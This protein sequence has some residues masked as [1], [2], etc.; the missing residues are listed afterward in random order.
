MISEVVPG[1]PSLCSFL[2]RD[3]YP[4][5]L[6]EV[7]VVIMTFHRHRGSLQARSPARGGAL[8]Y[9]LCFGLALIILVSALLY[10]LNMTL[11]C[12]THDQSYIRARFL[13]DSGVYLAMALMKGDY[14]DWVAHV[15]PRLPLR[16]DRFS[17]PNYSLE[18]L[19]GRFEI[20]EAS[21]PQAYP[22][23]ASECY[24]TL[25]S[26]GYSG[27]RTARSFVTIKI[28]SPLVNNVIFSNG[29]FDFGCWGDPILTGPVLVNANGDEGRFQAGHDVKYFSV[30]SGRWEHESF[31]ISL[32]S[33]IKA[34]GKIFL[35]SWNDQGTWSR[36]PIYFSGKTAAGDYTIQDIPG[37]VNHGRLTILT[38]LNAQPDMETKVKI[39]S[40][41]ELLSSYKTK[42][43]TTI[44]DVGSC[45]DG[46]LAEFVEG[47]NT[48][49]ISS[50]KMKTVGKVFDK[51]IYLAYRDELLEGMRDMCHISNPAIADQILKNSVTWDD[52]DYL[53]FAYPP[54]LCGDLDGDGT[55]ETQGDYFEVK[56]PVRDS[57]I[58]SITLSRDTPKVVY[59]RTNKTDYAGE[60]GPQAP[61]LYV[62][63]NV[64]GKVALVYDVADDS[65]DPDFDRLHTCILAQDEASDDGG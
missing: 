42:P 41:K 62:R 29:N 2:I 59:L 35:K 6:H 33:E 9:V 27:L 4:S 58:A 48:L 13:A 7:W 55:S 12:V 45:A 50:A 36:E 52:P 60:R 34:Q 32:S 1:G 56:R 20:S 63:G 22:P 14:D 38:E 18:A 25:V 15:R 53:P 54:D 21:I 44:V 10:R 65:L 24:M 30:Y 51:D 43:G 11:R 28:T 49:H 31:H 5:V 37:E 47:T 39:P 23:G 46:V 64:K 3:S 61:I 17:D 57:V 26:T 40:M 8:V 19:G 16:S